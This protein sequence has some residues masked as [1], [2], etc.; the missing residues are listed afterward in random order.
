M[1]YYT[2]GTAGHV[3]HGKTTLVKA[4]TGNDTDRLKE[5][6][7][8]GISI[9]LGFTAMELADK[10]VGIVDVPGH[11]KFVKQ[12]VAGVAGIDLVLLVISADEGVM[13]Q[14]LEHLDILTLLGVDQGIIVIN[15]VDLVDDEWLEL[16]KEDIRDKLAA[17]SLRSAPIMCVSGT[18]GRGLSDLRDLINEQLEKISPKEAVGKIR[19][20]VD[21]S[22]SVTGFG[23]VVTG[24]LWSGEICL[25][26]QLAIYPHG[27][28]AR[29]RNIQV[30]GKHVESV[31]AGRRTALNLGNVAVEDVPRGAVLAEKGS[32][33]PS[34]RLDIQFNLLERVSKKINHRAPVRIHLGTKE[35]IGR[36]ILLDREEVEPGSQV[37][38]QIV[39]DE[40]VVAM[41]GDNFVIRSYSPMITI[42]GGKVIDGAAK[43]I[44]RYKEDFIEQ[45]KI[46]L[47]GTPADLINQYIAKQGYDYIDNLAE[48]IGLSED[49]V[50]QTM[51]EGDELEEVMI[52]SSELGITAAKA[53]WR[54]LTNKA[55]EL[56]TSYH[57]QYP[58]RPGI[59]K[60]ELR[61]RIGN[62][63]QKIFNP[64]I[65]YWQENK[66][67]EVSDQYVL[68]KGFEIVLKDDQRKTVT[69]ITEE[70]R[71]QQLQP[72]LKKEVI[73]KYKL[74]E[75][76]SSE[77]FNFMVEKG[78]LVKI[79]EELYFHNSAIAKAKSEV[80]NIMEESGSII[81]GDVRDKLN[82]SRKFVL[83]LLEYLDKIKYTKRFGDK[84][85]LY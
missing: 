21:R 44:K 7:E 72:P 27:G 36:I 24:T 68:V 66:T 13:P 63:D 78:E 48:A 53:Y 33:T 3:D 8:R 46:K 10:Q 28:E 82:S 69:R 75:R 50:K 84:R 54:K 19:I 60:E 83:P 26:E 6:K 67:L 5:E 12:M 20:P 43:K 2:V 85:V 56:I 58:L 37:Y 76:E 81:L 17:S 25:G 59:A 9:E 79:N 15:K 14:T 45:F 1:N 77:L 42:G 64:F 16:V 49:Q 29:V 38:C 51:L 32:L 70:Y 52:I 47:Q 22:F 4:L 35:V 11:E 61:T 34:F 18:T 39:T 71:T 40:P 30:H 57:N 31:A 80:A 73:D 74:A 23:T 62:M 41:R 55:V 65:H